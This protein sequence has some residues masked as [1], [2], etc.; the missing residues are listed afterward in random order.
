ML[1]LILGIRS[2]PSLGVTTTEGGRNSAILRYD[3]APVAEPS[4][5]ATINP[6][7]LNEVNLHVS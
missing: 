6:V 2:I 1:T 3:S 4:T 7:L 5:N